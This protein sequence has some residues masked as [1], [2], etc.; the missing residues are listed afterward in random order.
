LKIQNELDELDK[1][2]YVLFKNILMKIKNLF[3]K[4]N[5]QKLIVK[6]FK[7]KYKFLKIW[8]SYPKSTYSMFYNIIYNI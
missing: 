8:E 7:Y 6:R 3:I 1:I 5:Y 4:N 2:S